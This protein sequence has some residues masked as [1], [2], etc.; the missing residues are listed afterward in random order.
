MHVVTVQFQVHPSKADA[1]RA[2]IT[3]QAATSLTQEPDCLQ[4]DVAIDPDDPASVFLYELYSDAETFQV[5]L[6][7]SHFKRF[8]ETVK[9]WVISKTVTILERIWPARY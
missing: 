8:D 6:E 5:H 3:E 9:P 2:A 7:T 1:F 4:F